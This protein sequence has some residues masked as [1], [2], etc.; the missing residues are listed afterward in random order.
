ME[1]LH[2]LREAITTA[3]LTLQLHNTYYSPIKC[4]NKFNLKVISSKNKKFS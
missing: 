1:Q 2:Y 4:E 3:T